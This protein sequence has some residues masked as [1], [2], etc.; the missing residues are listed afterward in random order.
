MPKVHS[1]RMATVLMAGGVSLAAMQQAQAAGF[2]LKEQSAQSQ[3]NAFAGATAT[4]SDLST[5]YFNPAGMTRLKHS[6]M[7]TNISYIVPSSTLSLENSSNP[8]SGLG[9]PLGNG[10]GGDAGAAC[11]FPHFTACIA[12]MKT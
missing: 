2:Q 5:I 4:A 7:D 12:M 10:N 9:T 3:G 8:T 11:S 1:I 6:G